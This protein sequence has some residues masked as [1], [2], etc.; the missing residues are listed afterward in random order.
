[1]KF[2]KILKKKKKRYVL[3]ATPKPTP[4]RRPD[5]QVSRVV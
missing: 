5:L 3:D 1:M 4:L 2:V